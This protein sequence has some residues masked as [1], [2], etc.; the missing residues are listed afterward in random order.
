VVA[1]ASGRVTEIVAGRGAPR[2][3]VDVIRVAEV[4]VE[5][6]RVPLNATAVAPVKR[7]P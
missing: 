6:A 7:F 3:P 5:A 4:T 1:G 2:A